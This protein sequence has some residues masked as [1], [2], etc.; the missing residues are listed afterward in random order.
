[1]CSGSDGHGCT[2][3]YYRGGDAG[4]GI[5]MEYSEVKQNCE[6]EADSLAILNTDR[7]IN[8]A[9]ELWYNNTIAATVAYS[10]WIGAGLKTLCNYV[11]C[12]N[13]KL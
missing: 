13:N 8:T 2:Y 4:S 6:M 10:V 9:Y 11:L 1:M 12:T 3:S 7:A 5:P